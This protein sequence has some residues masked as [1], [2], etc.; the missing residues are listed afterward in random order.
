MML[1][2]LRNNDLFLLQMHSNIFI[3]FTKAMQYYV[4]RL[5]E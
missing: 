1:K 4:K 5:F 3:D 2:V